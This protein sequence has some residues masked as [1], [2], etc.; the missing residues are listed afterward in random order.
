MF[1]SPACMPGVE[2]LEGVVAEVIYV[3]DSAVV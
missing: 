1:L 2:A 3:D